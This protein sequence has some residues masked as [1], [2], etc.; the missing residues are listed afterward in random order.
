MLD[1][2]TGPPFEPI[3]TASLRA[4]SLKTA[5]LLALASV[6][7]VGDLQALSIDDLCIEFGP[8]DC[9]LTLKPR[10]GYVPKV[11]ST[12]FKEQVITLS[13][14]CPETPTGTEP[15][16][17]LLLCPIRAERTYIER[18][19]QFRLSEQLFVCFGGR[20]KGL[21]VSKQRLSHW[22]VDAIALAYSSKGVGCPIG[23]Q[24]HSTRGLVSS[25]AW[26]NAISIQDICMA[27][28]W[29]SPST[30]VRFYNLDVSSLAS[31]VLSVRAAHAPTQP[32]L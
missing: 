2:L 11:L 22:I 21:P 23:I 5:L 15:L 13:A 9:R 30:F 3:Q 29:S 6:K 20:T 25:W 7:R 10:K 1:A 26:A 32:Q 31:H 27:A 24:A 14:F 4:L 18:S 19:R 16:N 17:T 12:P 8:G 28:G